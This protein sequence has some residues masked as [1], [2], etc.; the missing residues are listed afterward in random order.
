[1]TSEDNNPLK[2]IKK[3]NVYTLDFFINFFQNRM[4]YLFEYFVEK[5]KKHFISLL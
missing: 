2:L 1:M 5:L 4:F 3:S